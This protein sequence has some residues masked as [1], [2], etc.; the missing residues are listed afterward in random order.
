L[1]ELALYSSQ[2]T[3]GTPPTSA[4]LDA[5]PILVGSTFTT[6]PTLAHAEPFQLFT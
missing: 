3:Y 5:W 2:A 4:S 6:P 1:T